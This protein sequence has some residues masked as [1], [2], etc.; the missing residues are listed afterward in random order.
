MRSK[1]TLSVSTVD[2]DTRDYVKIPRNHN[3]I[4][5]LT[6]PVLEV[7]V[8]HHKSLGPSFFIRVIR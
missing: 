2:A 6:V 1:Y 7:R 8:I 5:F 4:E 3:G